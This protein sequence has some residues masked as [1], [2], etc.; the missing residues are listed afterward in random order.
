[1]KTPTLI[2]LLC[3]AVLTFA[4]AAPAQTPTPDPKEIA[5]SS[6]SPTPPAV[7]TT[8]KESKTPAAATSKSGEKAAVKTGDA[9][10]RAAPRGLPP[11]PPEKQ[12][13]VS[14]VRFDAPPVIDGKLDD[15]VWKK[16]AVFKDFYQINP[17]DNIAP[18]LPTETFIG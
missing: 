12:Q 14:I 18:A 1:M 16:A 3:A 4:S 11:L 15:A 6:P 8:D 13:A 2:A 7:T 10:A 9:T 5:A 17:G